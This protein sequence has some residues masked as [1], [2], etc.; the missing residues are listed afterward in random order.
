MPVQPLKFAD[1]WMFIP[2][3]VN[4]DRAVREAMA[5]PPINHRGA[6]FKQLFE[7]LRPKTQWLFRTSNPVYFST[8]SAVGI[9]EA[10]ARNCIARRS[11][12]LVNGAFSGSWFEISR[13]CGKEA[14]AQA[15]DWGCA[16]RPEQLREML[17]SG[18]YD[19]VC[20]V[21][22]ETSTSVQNPIAEM[23]EVLREFP[24]VVFCLDTVSAL[25]ASPVEV[26]RWGV[27]VC[28][29]SV[30]KGIALPPGF[31]V[32]SVSEK[33]MQRARG[34][35]GRGFYFD[36]LV[37][38]EFAQRSNTPTTPSVSHMFALNTQL[39]R[40]RAEGL[41]NR[42]ARHRRLAEMSQ[43]WADE[44]YG[45]YAEAGYRSDAVTAVINKGTLDIGK[46][47]AHLAESG[48]VVAGGYGPLKD[49]TFRIGHVG[50]TRPEQLQTLLDEIDRFANA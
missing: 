43:Q 30:Q 40:I 50:E 16:N 1:H 31:T 19:T 36:F 41:E 22:S 4:V 45:C 15:V 21:Q 48:M 47:N 2:G 44:R 7:A 18:L 6:E 49:S 26:D 24:D 25:A 12:H 8:S 29:A 35:A 14:D 32:F 39:D 11:L 23:A 13:A 9:M 3:P 10:A 20:M 27:D 5:H 17:M 42:W 37:F 28:F 38:E 34:V 33:A 46:L